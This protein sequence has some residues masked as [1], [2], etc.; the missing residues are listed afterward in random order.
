MEVRKEAT[1]GV[2][3][4]KAKIFEREGCKHYPRLWLRALAAAAEA[5]AGAAAAAATARAGAATAKA[6]TSLDHCSVGR[7]QEDEP[8]DVKAAQSYLDFCES[9]GTPW[10][11]FNK[12]IHELIIPTAQQ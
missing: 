4:S 12:A 11:R 3:R 10:V 8:E 9:K 6:A 5:G 7:L 2:Y 1:V